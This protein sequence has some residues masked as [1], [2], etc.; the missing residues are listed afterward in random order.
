[1]CRQDGVWQ[2]HGEVFCTE[3]YL[4]RLLLLKH[5]TAQHEWCKKEHTLGDQKKEDDDEEKENK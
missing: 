1:M 4:S 5:S 3:S 2:S